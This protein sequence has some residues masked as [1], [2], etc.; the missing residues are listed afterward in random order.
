EARRLTE[1]VLSAVVAGA[2]RDGRDP[3][4]APV[5]GA[6]P[7][8]AARVVTV[9]RF[10]AVV[11]SPSDARRA[12]ERLREGAR[13]PPAASNCRRLIAE[14]ARLE[15]GGVPHSCVGTRSEQLA[16]T[17]VWYARRAAEGWPGPYRFGA[18][19][20]RIPKN[21]ATDLAAELAIGRALKAMAKA[22]GV[23]SSA[24]LRAYGEALR[25]LA[26]S[27][28]S[29]GPSLE[30]S[31]TALVDEAGKPNPTPGVAEINSSLDE[32]Y[33][34]LSRVGK[35]CSGVGACA[36]QARRDAR[37]AIERRARGW[38]P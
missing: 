29:D 14:M 10:D 22:G 13:R 4:S 12:E 2:G 15:T 8:R 20:S 26:S 33:G 9:S 23:Q 3:E 28:P 38:A 36:D 17:E 37:E 30:A 27:H 25:A 18:Y 32:Y 7:E 19:A 5:H 24:A 1:A 35:G 6:A 31:G 34:S 16:F 21:E 11:G